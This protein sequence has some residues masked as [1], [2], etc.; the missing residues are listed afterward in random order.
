MPQITPTHLHDCD[1]CRFIT[2]TYND[3]GDTFD[4]YICG[5][6]STMP[7]LVGRYGNEGAQYWSMDV[8]TLEANVGKPTFVMSENRYAWSER[9][10]IAF[11][12]YQW[13]RE[14]PETA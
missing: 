4:W 7:T 12:V 2:A 14:S 6:H 5:L 10:Q 11:T 1:Q 3:N 9:M 13:W 8:A